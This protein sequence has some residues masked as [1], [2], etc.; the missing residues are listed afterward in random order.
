MTTFTAKPSWE[1]HYHT[2]EVGGLL[3]AP[4]IERMG[5]GGRFFLIILALS[6]IGNNIPNIYS[7]RLLL[8]LGVSGS[9][10]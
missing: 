7:V 9:V 10:C 3:G 5:G 6:I 1:E 4:L 8:F 2:Y